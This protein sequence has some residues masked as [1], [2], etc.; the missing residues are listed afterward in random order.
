MR[1]RL[2]FVDDDVCPVCERR[3]YDK[4]RCAVVS[5]GEVVGYTHCVCAEVVA[6]LVRRLGD[7]DE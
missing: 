3:V 5:D 6:Q 4:D 7:E 2:I 1:L